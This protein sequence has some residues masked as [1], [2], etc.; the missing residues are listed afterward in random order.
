MAPD[1]SFRVSLLNK[2]VISFET[3][4]DFLYPKCQKVRKLL[5]LPIVSFTGAGSMK[6]WCIVN[7]ETREITASLSTKYFAVASGF[8]NGS[9]GLSLI[10]FMDYNNKT[11]IST[12]SEI[13]LCKKK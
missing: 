2:Y 6:F 12:P 4:G 10:C 9:K 5:G 13:I 3:S 1:D 7:R 11:Y 8:V